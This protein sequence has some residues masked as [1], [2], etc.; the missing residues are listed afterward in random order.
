MSRAATVALAQVNGVLYE[1][2]EN[3]SRTLA[4]AARL[5]EDGADI[6]VLP[7]LIASGYGTDG[8][9]LNEAAEPVDGPTTQAWGQLAARHGGLIVGGICERDRDA[10]YNAAVLVGEGGVLL[11]YRKLHLFRTEKDTFTAGDLGLPVAET[12]FGVIGLCVCYDLRFVETV[13]ALALKGAELVCVPTAWLP[14]FDRERSDEEGYAPQARGALLQANLDQTFI[15]CASQAGD[16]GEA[17]F[18]GSSVLCDPYGKT[19]LGPLPPDREQL[20]AATVDLDQVDR[21]HARDTLINPQ[22]DRRT[23]VYGLAVDGVVL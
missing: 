2:E 15:A 6:V 22:A 7:E 17:D 19:V 3:R 16:N 1:P 8:A 10:L 18:L 21:A 23:D 9:G 14:G 13:R 11:H 12:R 20:A 5:F 4:A